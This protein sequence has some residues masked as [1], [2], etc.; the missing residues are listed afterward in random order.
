MKYEIEIEINDFLV[1]EFIKE[2]GEIKKPIEE[3]LKVIEIGLIAKKN[4]LNAELFE[5]LIEQSI[6]LLEPE[7]Y[8]EMYNV[9]L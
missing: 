5:D 6:K 1:E 4:P 8:N 3:I 9:D 2:F 7:K